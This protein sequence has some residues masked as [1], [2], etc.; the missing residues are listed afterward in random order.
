MRPGQ[1]LTMVVCWIA[2]PAIVAAVIA[3][4]AA[5]LLTSGT[6][7]DMTGTAHTGIP[8]SFSQV[9]PPS[10]L[11]LL[12][13]GALLIAIAGAMLPAT[14]AAREA[15]RSPARRVRPL[16]RDPDVRRPC[17]VLHRVGVLTLAINGS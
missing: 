16:Q 7:G 10:R 1:M 14:W 12:S 17:P 8:A 15:S 6:V 4:P 11:A 9:L 13:L 2:G 3:A 5:V